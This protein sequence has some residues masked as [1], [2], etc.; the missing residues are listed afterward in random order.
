MPPG[1]GK[2]WYLLL[3]AGRWCYWCS[4]PSCNTALGE[5]M[6]FKSV[7]CIA[8]QSNEPVHVNNNKVIWPLSLFKGVWTSTSN[9]HPVLVFEVIYFILLHR[10]QRCEME[11]DVS[12]LQFISR[13]HHSSLFIFELLR[14]SFVKFLYSVF[15]CLNEK[16]V[17]K[18]PTFSV[19]FFFTSYSCF[20]QHKAVT[21]DS[22]SLVVF[23]SFLGK[24]FFQWAVCHLHPGLTGSH[25]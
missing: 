25:Y 5:Y 15:K 12:F 23:L 22:F 9:R 3:Y 7:T 1:G 24:F 6:P 11:C 18:R 13:S 17:I 14:C 20:S 8:L 21:S 16:Q 2:L 10:K 19:L 4:K